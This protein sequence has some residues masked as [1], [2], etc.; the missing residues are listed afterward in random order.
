MSI[1]STPLVS[2]FIVTYNRSRLVSK[3]IQ[4]VLNQTYPNIE[5]VVV[6]DCSPDDTYSVV[7]AIQAENE[8]IRYIKLN[9]QSGANVA[10]NQGILNATGH[11]VTG[12]DDDDKMTPDR[13]EKLVNSFDETYA[14]VFSQVYYVYPKLIQKKRLKLLG[15]HITFDDMLYTNITGNQVLT[16]RE[17]YLEAGLYDQ[18]LISAQDYDMW[19]KLLSIKP[20]A[21]LVREPLLLVDR[22]D[23]VGR[24]S[25]SKKYI[26]GYF[27]VYKKY[28]KYMS[29]DQR[30]F[31]L[32]KLLMA[33]NK[34]LPWNAFFD[35]FSYRQC[36]L[37]TYL[38]LKMKRFHA[39]Y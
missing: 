38:F 24:I 4:S 15:H 22:D 23:S 1:N 6:D 39:A 25:N 29:I 21:K 31:Q 32:F 14:Y 17:M 27:A 30:R 12:L 7:K 37:Y 20:K 33:K 5:I 35:Y 26:Q 2:V 36:I 19:L 34:N 10:R 18:N 9:Q 16:T 11:F 13:I 3:A 28:K 8:N